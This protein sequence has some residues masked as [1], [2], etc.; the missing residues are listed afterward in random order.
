MEKR[1]P[2][3]VGAGGIPQLKKSPEIGGFRELI[4]AILSSLNLY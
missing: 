2:D 4:E 3:Y 1:C